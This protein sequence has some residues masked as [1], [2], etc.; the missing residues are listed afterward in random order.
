M[1]GFFGKLLWIDLTQESYREETIPGEILERYL[2]GKGLGSYLLLQHLVPGTDPLGPENKLIFTPGP[3]SDSPM[4][5][6]SRYGVFSK[7]PQT[8]LY[9]ESY[10]GGRV[11]PVMKRTG[12][13]AIILAGKA[14]APV[15]V[16]ISDSGVTFRSAARLWGLDTY[17]T[18][19]A[20]LQEV[21]V[22]GAQAVV[23]GPAGENL[24][25]F[26][27]IENNYWRSAGR[28]GL[29]AV[30]GSKL[31]KALVFHGQASC[32]VADPEGLQKFVR[33]FREK[34]LANPGAKAYREY[35]TP[36]MVALMN[37]NGVFP[38]RYW[39]QGTFESWEKISAEYL[40]DN[41]EVKPRAC[42]RCVFA[43]GKLSTVKQGRHAGLT[44]E[45]PEY[46]TIYAFGGLC[47]IDSMEEIVYLNDLC[48]RLGMDTISAGNLVALAM[49]ARERSQLA[50]GP[51]YGDPEG[52]AKLL[53]EIA[54]RQG[55][56]SLFADGIVAASRALGLEDLAIHVKGLEPP[57]YDPR[58]LKGMGLAYATSTRG[59]CH[60]RAT[61]YKP[62]LA[63]M[64]D[65]ETVQG[66]AELFVEFENRLT[67][68]D[69][70]ILC[71]FMRDLL[72]W[73]D[74]Q[75]LI[76]CT[77]GRNYTMQ[78]LQKMA[79]SIV[80]LTRDFNLREGCGRKQDTLP[81]RFF[82]ETIG[83]PEKNLRPEELE[84]MV[85]EYYRI[86]GW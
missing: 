76:R 23:I 56:G 52:A 6:V 75:E 24:V 21:G 4:L 70:Q 55:R 49:E 41:L 63:G 79:N 14:K 19:D 42:T 82:R 44:V 51:A 18:E 2:G 57:G 36:M 9:A 48:D 31:V 33:V 73:E 8:G 72:P 7:S 3:T 1:H 85:D 67:I 43:C 13:D 81:K 47:C 26:A 77:T 22:K 50:D 74:L 69:T 78:E 83:D 34:S 27:C 39:S 29:G 71:R 65:R 11:A 53:R 30:M 40:V 59:A 64:I 20:V 12:Y 28:T 10:S 66:K 62:E 86:R 25:K 5:G 60:L 35:G 45:G 84:F 80:T 17:A 54:A 68:F 46:E 16:E 58:L 15:Y 37:S 38:T 32:E 61:F